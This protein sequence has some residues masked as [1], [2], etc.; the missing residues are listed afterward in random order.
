MQ[1]IP[2]GEKKKKKSKLFQFAL[3]KLFPYVVCYAERKTGAAVM[4]GFKH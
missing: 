2:F 4:T 3:Q 1:K